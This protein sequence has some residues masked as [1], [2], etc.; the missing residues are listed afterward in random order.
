MPIDLP[1]R[2]AADTHQGYLTDQPVAGI[3]RREFHHTMR[4]EVIARTTFFAIHVYFFA[5][6][7]STPPFTGTQIERRGTEKV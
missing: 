7:R 5:V 4:W 6:Y 2:S 3:E 1:F